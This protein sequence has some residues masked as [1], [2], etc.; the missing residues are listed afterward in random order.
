MNRYR[1]FSDTIIEEWLKTSQKAL[2]VHGLP[3]IGKE[4]LIIE[5]LKERM[6]IFEIDCRDR[7]IQDAFRLANHQLSFQRISHRPGYTEEAAFVFSHA[8]SCAGLI[9]RTKA[10]LSTGKR[11]VFVFDRYEKT[12]Q[13]SK[14]FPLGYVTEL[15]VEP[16]TFTEY[17]WANGVGQTDLLRYCDAA[18]EGK[19]L[20]EGVFQRF[21]QLWDR[22]LFIGGYPAVVKADMQGKWASRELYLADA[23]NKAAD[24]IR[25]C[26]GKKAKTLYA[27]VGHA[28]SGFFDR[29]VS[30][31]AS[32]GATYG[33]YAESI[34][35]L[36][37]R[38]LLVK[39]PYWQ[40]GTPSKDVSLFYPDS[41]FMR[42][43]LGIANES[44][45]TDGAYH[46]LEMGA[47]ARVL[48]RKGFELHKEH[49]YGYSPD[50]I[51]RKEADEFAV[52]IKSGRGVRL[53]ID[54]ILSY[55]KGKGLFVL[56]PNNRIL[57]EDKQ[58][59]L[60]TCMFALMVE[61]GML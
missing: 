57:F 5:F 19:P 36:S 8:D 27:S 30:S 4:T 54:K 52:E 13:E 45:L 2:F 53:R 23:Q 60:P 22:Y 28:R 44:E 21:Q 37:E 61:G 12:L 17:C 46:L 55:P 1:R 47:I 29:F 42:S 16:L 48:N 9:E 40:N 32:K 49:S 7:E 41:G 26:Y 15:V 43:S 18:K 14:F 11:I 59:V 33:T 25:T 50:L 35:L 24:Y 6:P 31:R 56:S 39:V 58:K 10:L 51:C 34:E 38:R 3:G 20:P